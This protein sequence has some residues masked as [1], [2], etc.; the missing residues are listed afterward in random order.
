MTHISISHS[1]EK[2]KLNHVGVKL[3]PKAGSLAL[4]ALEKQLKKNWH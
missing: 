2:N 1:I 4:Y 3:I